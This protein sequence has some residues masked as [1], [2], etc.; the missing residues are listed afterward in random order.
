MSRRLLPLAAL[1]VLAAL[2]LGLVLALRHEPGGRQARLDGRP[3]S[4]VGTLSPREPQFGDTVVAT[5]DVFVDSRRVDPDTVRVT[6]GFTP[7]QVTA[8]TRMVRSDEGVS[9]T[10]LER[11]LRCLGV[12]CVPPGTASTVR[13]EPVRVSYR[14][15]SQPRSLAVAWP[16]LHV[17]SRVALADL[18]HPLLRVPP[19]HAASDYRLPPRPTGYAL[20]AL[21][22]LLALGGSTLLL[23]VGLRR[24]APVRRGTNTPLERILV[25]LAAASS[26]GDSGRRRRALEQLARELEPLDPGL[27]VES[28][29]LA[30]GPED[31]KVDAVADLAGRAQTAVRR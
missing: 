3:V 31:P 10:H 24:F 12:A 2:V 21:A 27:S 9:I 7:Y 19:P 25:E 15:G 11:R 5:V 26:N 29:V 22:A 13:F 23:L 18:R 14:E 28:R 30:W 16:V 6:T 8:S 17:H 20:L 1:V 4:A